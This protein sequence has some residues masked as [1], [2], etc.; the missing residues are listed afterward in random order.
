MMD[1]ADDIAFLAASEQ[2]STVLAS[3]YGDGPLTR[4]D[5]TDRCNAARVTV[6]RNIE[7]LRDR[8]MIEE[9]VDGFDLTALGAALAEDF[10]A[11][12]E[13][14]SVADRLTPVLRHVP[15]DTF[16]LDIRALADADVTVSTR[17]DPYAPVSRHEQTLQEATRVRVLLPAVGADPLSTAVDRLVDRKLDHE[18]VVSADVA[19]ALRTD[20]YSD[21]IEKMLQVDDSALLVYD[22]DV[23]YY[24][25]IVDDTVQ[26]G[27]D[28]DD[29]IP[30]AL[31]ES[32]AEQ[33]RKWAA[34]TYRSFR[35]STEPFDRDG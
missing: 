10:V 7:K 14:V 3:L 4:E 1:A 29:G 20:A 33:V 2:R 28:D 12:A 31:A 17:A 23:P 27:V 6:D 18:L 16:D 11:M 30:R 35:S 21:E 8:G 34:K 32:D 25:G 9:N 13:T 26:I 19:S 22:G 24:L 5:L 15:R